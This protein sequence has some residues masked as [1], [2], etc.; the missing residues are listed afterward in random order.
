MLMHASATRP[1]CIWVAEVPMIWKVFPTGI[2]VPRTAVT[3][4]ATI[5]S[6]AVAIL[7]AST[8]GSAPY[9]CWRW[10]SAG[11]MTL[12]DATL[13]LRRRMA[14]GNALSSTCVEERMAC[15]A[16]TILVP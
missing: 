13:S 1:G 4:V 10:I 7:L 3:L 8:S 5:S 16:R 12:T 14:E 6:V 11:N 15:E 9:M 2:I